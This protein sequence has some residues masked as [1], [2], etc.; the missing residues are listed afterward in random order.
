MESEGQ[1]QL[2]RNEERL[3]ENDRTEKRADAEQKQGHSQPWPAL[4]IGV[5]ENESRAI[6]WKIRLH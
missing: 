5:G 2:W 4:A 3:D 6:G 1:P